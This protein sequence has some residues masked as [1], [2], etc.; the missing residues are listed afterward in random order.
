M[1]IYYCKISELH[2]HTWKLYISYHFRIYSNFC[3]SCLASI[4]FRYCSTEFWT[5]IIQEFVIL[6][7]VSSVQ[8]LRIGH[9]MV[10]CGRF[11]SFNRYSFKLV[12]KPYFHFSLV[13]FLIKKRKLRDSFRRKRKNVPGEI[14]SFFLVFFW[15]N[16]NKKCKY[17]VDKKFNSAPVLRVKR[18]KADGAFQKFHLDE[19]ACWK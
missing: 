9:A 15:Q 3:H 1:A 6:H 12:F 11:I 13:N 8:C 7:Q 5:V 16:W 10:H 19:L 14:F 4:F 18:F 17:H 2:C